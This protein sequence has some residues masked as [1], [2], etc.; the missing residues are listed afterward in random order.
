M[1]P[2]K[3]STSKDSSQVVIHGVFD[4]H[5]QSSL[6]GIVRSL[7][8]NQTVTTSPTT[9]GDVACSEPNAKATKFTF[10]SSRSVQVAYEAKP[11]AN[12]HQEVLRLLATSKDPDGYALHDLAARL[13]NVRSVS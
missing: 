2:Y 10:K 13:R 12:D 11:F 7:S 3:S 6:P 1:V 4:S 9:S 8:T 5:Y